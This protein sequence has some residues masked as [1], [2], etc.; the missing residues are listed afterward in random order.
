MFVTHFLP[1][2][3]VYLVSKIITKLT[4]SISSS[5]SSIVDTVT[6]LNLP[7][8]FVLFVIITYS[9]SSMTKTM[10]QRDK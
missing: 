8:S 6:E 7:N 9:Q 10:E 5:S 2:L 1:A 3:A 4:C